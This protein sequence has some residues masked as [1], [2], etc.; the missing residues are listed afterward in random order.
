MFNKDHPLYALPAGLIGS[1]GFAYYPDVTVAL[2]VM[3]KMLQVCYLFNIKHKLFFVRK[4]FLFV[5]G[6]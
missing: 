1:I 2:Y 4:S 6:L 5:G 3:W